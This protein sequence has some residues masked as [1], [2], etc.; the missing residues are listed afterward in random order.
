M[1]VNFTFCLH[2]LRLSP[3]Y[4]DL[5]NFSSRCS[6]VA[7]PGVAAGIQHHHQDRRDEIWYLWHFQRQDSSCDLFHSI[8]KR[9]KHKHTYLCRC[10]KIPSCLI[11]I[12]KLPMSGNKQPPESSPHQVGDFCGCFTQGYRK[13][14]WN[15]E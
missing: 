2:T 1:P 3:F 6:L 12:S 11:S 9:G 10:Q 5:G 15:E 7:L 8:N 4:L 13:P 14:P